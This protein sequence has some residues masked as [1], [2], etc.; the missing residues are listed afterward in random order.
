[1]FKALFIATLMLL[2]V[3]TYAQEVD[4]SQVIASVEVSRVETVPLIE[5]PAVPGNP[6]DEIAMYLDGLIAIGKKI[7]PII[8][9]G[10]PV[11]NTT[12]I[13]PSLSVIPKIEGADPKAAFYDMA[14]WSAPKAESYRVSYKNKFGSEVIGF[15]YTVYFQFNGDYNG[16]GKYI[17]NLKV[18]ASEVYAAWG[19]N[20]SAT[21]E[22]IGIANVGSKEDPTAS[23][24]IQISYIAKGLINEVRNAQSFYVD[25][26]GTMRLLKN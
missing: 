15:T 7:W 24:I 20:F 1:M 8:D 4:E 2:N 17:T 21:S 26:Q 13:I 9:A 16:K 19:F 23:A 11:I 22:L 12:G 3:S 25:G 5:V 6:I 10:R 18:Q 14:N